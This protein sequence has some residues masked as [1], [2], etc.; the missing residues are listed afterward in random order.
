MGIQAFNDTM[1]PICKSAPRGLIK[2][3]HLFK[4]QHLFQVRVL[5]VANNGS[6]KR[7]KTVIFF[8][9]FLLKC[10]IEIFSLS[11]SSNFCY[12][13]ISLLYLYVCVGV[14]IVRFFHF[15]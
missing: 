4:S 11:L 13:S 9:S 3:R 7:H 2:R 6:F 12:L 10:Y 15:K 1:A 5:L 14:Y 8:C